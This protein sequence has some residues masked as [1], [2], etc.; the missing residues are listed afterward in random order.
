MQKTYEVLLPVVIFF[1]IFILGYIVRKLILNRLT[2]WTEKTRTS[3]DDIIVSSIKGPF[4]IWCIM[5]AVYSAF[6]FS[7]FSDEVVTFIGKALLSLG[8]LSVTLVIA[9]IATRIIKQ[10]SSEKEGGL[11]LPSLTEN[12]VR[13]VILGI[14]ILVILNNLGISI[15]P[16]LTALGIGGLAVA[17][18]LQDTLSNLFAGFYISFTHQISVGDFVK[19]ESGDEGYVLDIGWRATRIRM[20]PN[21][22][23]IIPNSKL[24]QSIITNYYLPDKEM[25]VLVPV[26]VHY[27][28]DLDKVEEITIEVAKEV[29]REVEGGVPEFEPFIRYHTFNDF[30]INFNVILRTKEVVNQ[31]LIRHEF[32]KRLHKR[33]KKEKIVIPYPIRAI[34]YE[35][36]KTG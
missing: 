19:L 32:I 29:M 28:S 3:I 34:N 15:T 24:A 27:S 6:K 25:A 31:H 14:G 2:K 18:A 12:I 21:N 7:H 30:S 33:Y 35:Q 1:F 8:I 4:I 22:V 20:L 11:P 36:E 17:L 9:G 16:L 23:I 5:L 10:Y 26:G 13:I